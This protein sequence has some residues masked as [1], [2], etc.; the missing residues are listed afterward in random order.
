M[1]YVCKKN[2]TSTCFCRSKPGVQQWILCS[3][4]WKWAC[5]RAQLPDCYHLRYNIDQ[6]WRQ[7]EWHD[8]Q[9]RVL[10]QLLWHL[11]H[12]EVG[13]RRD[14][15]S[16]RLHLRNTCI[17]TSDVRNRLAQPRTAS[18]RPQFVRNKDRRGGDIPWANALASVCKTVSGQAGCVNLLGV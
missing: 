9:D 12:R 10:R 4:I 14:D 5:V 3:C 17:E 11:C 7:K 18:I 1:I 8:Q 16:Q 6:E 15:V 2:I 13:Q